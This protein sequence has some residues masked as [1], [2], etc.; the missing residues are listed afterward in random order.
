M[1]WRM[2]GSISGR[3]T[4]TTTCSPLCSVAQCTWA[5]DAEAIGVFSKRANSSDTGLPSAFSIIATD[6]SCGKAGTL[7]CSLASSSAISSGSKSR[8][9]DSIC[10]NFINTG[11]NSSMARRR[12]TPRGSSGTRCKRHGARPRAKRGSAESCSTSIN[13][14]SR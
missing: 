1:S 13:S 10:P 7:S 3:T 6:C 14:S 12:R 8:R 2:I 4:L 11:P 5:T 9:V